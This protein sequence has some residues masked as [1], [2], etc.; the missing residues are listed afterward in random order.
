MSV[1]KGA[2][3]DELSS[4]VRMKKSYERA[5]A[6]L[7]KGSLVKKK[8]K[9]HFYYYVVSRS[10]GKVVFAYKGK[11]LSAAEI[12]R[13]QDAKKYRAQYRALLSRT[14]KQVRFLRSALRGKEA[15]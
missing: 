5:L 7:P 15:I 14:K 12:K 13:Y 1:I 3:K 2:L 8:I 10:G 11:K 6:R 9:G 4:S